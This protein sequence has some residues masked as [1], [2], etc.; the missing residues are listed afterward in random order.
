MK[1]HMPRPCRGLRV[2]KAAI[3]LRIV[4]HPPKCTLPQRSPP[5]TC[6]HR[7]P[8]PYLHLN[9]SQA[10]PYQRL[11]TTLGPSWRLFFM[12]WLGGAQREN[13]LTK[14][15]CP[16]YWKNKDFCLKLLTYF[17]LLV[18]ASF[19]LAYTPWTKRFLFPLSPGHIKNL[20][21]C[22]RKI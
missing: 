12:R 18:S 11:G 9:C 4:L 10:S 14:N 5:A 17:S 1:C 3:V 21:Q 7:Q 6:T 19:V 8:H 22:E 15:A 16:L 20:M 13:F 2:R